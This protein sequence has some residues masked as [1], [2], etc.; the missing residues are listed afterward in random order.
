M[1]YEK[2]NWENQPS[3][4]T[5]IN[6]TNLNHMDDGIY[7]AHERINANSIIT[8][9]TGETILVTD[10]AKVPP[11]NIKLFGKTTQVS[12][13]GNQLFN[14]DILNG[15]TTCT[16]NDGNITVTIS[17][18]DTYLVG[19]YSITGSVLFALGADTYAIGCSDS[20]IRVSIY[21]VVD[22]T[23][24]GVDTNNENNTFNTTAN[25]VGVR[26]RSIDGT[27]LKGKTF[28]I[29]LNAGNILLN[30]EPYTGGQPSPSIDYP[31]ELNS[32]GDDGNVK[33]ALLGANL[34]NIYDKLQYNFEDCTIDDNDWCSVYYDNSTGNTTHYVGIQV[35]PS[36]YL[37]PNTEYLIVTETEY[38]SG[39][40]FFQ[41]SG[42]EQ[43]T[44]QG[45][46]I[47]TFSVSNP[48]IQI[49]KITTRDDFT[50]CVT[51]LRSIVAV[52]P[53]NVCRLKYRISVLADLSV[54][55]STFVYE[56]YTEQ[57]LTT[58]TPNGLPGLPIGKTILDEIKNS[59]IHMGGV[60]HDGEQY[61][62]G[63]TI[64]YKNGKYTQRI[65]KCVLDGSTAYGFDNGGYW[66]LSNTNIRA[67][68]GGDIITFADLH[69]YKNPSLSNYFIT[70]SDS[71][72]GVANEW[73]E[74]Y[75]T[76]YVSGSV[77]AIA[78]NAGMFPSVDEAGFKAFF[79][80]HPTEIYIIAK[81]PIETD[82]TSEELAQYNALCMNYPNTTITNDSEAYTEVEYVASPKE[83]IANLE[84][85]HDNDIQQ[86][87]TAIIALGG[88]I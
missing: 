12:T 60:Y 21:C 70:Q 51:M 47:N 69:G 62:I 50:G 35:K 86:L 84:K 33:Q 2:I 28:K 63:D 30:Y 24:Y 78:I 18:T 87:K 61:W 5:P 37:K 1:D 40:D 34:Y 80:A 79:T 32:C 42:M 67:L 16:E 19:S 74:H 4:K 58:L 14:P 54:T 15:S 20:N 56:P 66:H 59:P 64:D 22:G 48:G 77:G 52:N 49:N 7:E 29:M 82:L 31:Q 44:T 81:E 85:K 17:T 83:Y 75:N 53:G 23:I 43:A 41:V 57:T 72:G 88:T 26:I 55:A 71:Y 68:F 25:V 9:A 6:A 36:K 39:C 38:I 13:E 73:E 76:M 3:K 27:N 45:Q 10:S 46:F 65:L 8:T 11:E